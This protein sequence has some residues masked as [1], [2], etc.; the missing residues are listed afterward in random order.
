MV[1]RI[2]NNVQ[3]AAKTLKKFRVTFNDYQ[4]LY[5]FI[6]KIE[7]KV[8]ENIH[9]ESRVEPICDCRSGNIHGKSS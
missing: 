3:S 5:I 9:E 1:L 7:N 4:N 6:I 8:Y 2:D